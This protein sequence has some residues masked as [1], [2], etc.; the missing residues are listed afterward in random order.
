[1]Q[2]SSLFLIELQKFAICSKVVLFK[3]NE[4][5]LFTRLYCFDK[6]LL[7]NKIYIS[8]VFS[9]NSLHTLHT[10][11][12]EQLYF[13]IV[14]RDIFYLSKYNFET[15]VRTWT[16]CTS[17]P[18]NILVGFVKKKKNKFPTF[19]KLLKPDVPYYARLPHVSD[20]ER[21]FKHSTA[22]FRSQWQRKS[23]DNFFSCPLLSE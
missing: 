13:Q 5:Y 20:S 14:N 11:H 1:M 12:T 17:I 15:F 18:T 22:A 4:R 7:L 2:R 8:R 10:L 16:I 23:I 19:D 6:Y 9:T 3:E 21:V